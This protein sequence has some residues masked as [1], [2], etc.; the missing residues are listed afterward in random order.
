MSWF[1]FELE[2]PGSEVGGLFKVTRW[3]HQ[4]WVR[5][6]VQDQLILPG[7]VDVGRQPYVVGPIFGPGALS[8]VF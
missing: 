4:P 5:E 6:L 1:Q 3:H 2:L 8:K 7:G